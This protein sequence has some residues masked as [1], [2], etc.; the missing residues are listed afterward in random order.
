MEAQGLSFQT[1]LDVVIENE[2]LISATAVEHSVYQ[3]Q[4]QDVI[5][6]A[7]PV[8][9]YP[10]A[11]VRS[12]ANAER[13]EIDFYGHPLPISTWQDYHQ[14]VE[15]EPSGNLKSAH[16]DAGNHYYLGSHF[17]LWFQQVHFDSA[18]QLEAL[19]DAGGTVEVGGQI[20][21][22][23]IQTDVSFHPNGMVKTF[24][25]GANDNA[26]PQ[27]LYPFVL[28]GQTIYP[29]P[30]SEMVLDSEGKLLQFKAYV[31]GRV[32]TMNG[33]W[34]SFRQDEVVNLRGL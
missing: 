27:E 19:S 22:V 5:L 11:K 9:F 12:L 14:F 24:A 31:A 29:A 3:W 4:G 20:C 6:Q 21:R 23:Y 25:W 16:V 32:Q 30:G 34:I 28:W 1:G 8:Q 13:F 18:G 33:Q 26:I 15:F 2:T 10:N 7:K 17:E